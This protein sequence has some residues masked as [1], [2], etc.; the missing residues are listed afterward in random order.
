MK[1]G[2]LEFG[3]HAFRLVSLE[4]LCLEPLDQGNEGPMWETDIMMNLA[5]ENDMKVTRVCYYISGGMFITYVYR[6]G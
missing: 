3:T 4:Q 2:E 6:F 1:M 5:S